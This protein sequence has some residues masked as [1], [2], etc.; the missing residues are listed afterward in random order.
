MLEKKSCDMIVANNL[1]DAGSGFGH[2]TNKVALITK[3][4]IEELE[5]MSKQDVAKAI[6]DKISST[7]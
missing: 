1:K 2:D 7:I 4:D 5:L 3:E 6:L